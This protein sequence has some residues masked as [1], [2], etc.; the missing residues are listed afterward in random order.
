MKIKPN[1]DLFICVIVVVLA[2][3]ALA[4]VA[5]SPDQFNSAKAV[6]QGF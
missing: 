1:L 5:V 3:A 4:L 2:L 6:Y